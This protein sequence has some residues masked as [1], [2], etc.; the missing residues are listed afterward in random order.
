MLIYDIYT[1][2][3]VCRR[4]SL[5]GLGSMLLALSML[6]SELS[7][8]TNPLVVTPHLTET[9]FPRGVVGCQVGFTLYM[10]S[11]LVL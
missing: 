1:D 7:E 4:N 8:E 6:I 2:A 10:A 9:W 3:F 5:K 11:L